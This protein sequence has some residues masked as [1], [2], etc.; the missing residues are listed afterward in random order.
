[1]LACALL[2]CV[3]VSARAGLHPP[4]SQRVETTPYTGPKLLFGLGPEADV[5]RASALV[6]S[7]PVRMLTSW[8]NGPQDFE[9]LKTWQ[10][11]EIPLAYLDGYAMHL[12]V[13]ADG[14]EVP[15]NTRYGIACGR[16]YPLADRFLGDM[17]RLAETFAGDGAGPPLYV[18]LFTEFQTYPCRDSAWAPDP[19]TRAYYRALQDR[20]RATLKI[21]HRLAPNAQV[22]LGW[23]GWQTRWDDPAQGGGRSMFCHFANL[24]SASDFQ[25]FQA[26]ESQGNADD[27][28]A[29]T[30]TLGAYGPVMLAHLKPDN[31]SQATFDAD[32]RAIL[33]VPSLRQLQRYGLFA[34]SFMDTANLDARPET[35]DFV[36]RSVNRFGI[37]SSTDP[38]LP[39]ISPGARSA[40]RAPR[41]E[42]RGP[43]ARTRAGRG[44]CPG[45]ARRDS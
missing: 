27:I 21:F 33:T 35:L 2:A 38:R 28:A 18:T 15:L 5:A 29:M 11:Q 9:W 39:S 43:R 3:L 42:R 6:R 36:E 17:R 1:M 12:I 7:S 32:V 24:M 16:S 45:Q 37:R 25:S 44:S 19:A 22:S 10:T 20:Y 14:P 31:G 30:R 13:F 26:M 8:Y 34:L 23:G 40:Q 4:A 41:A